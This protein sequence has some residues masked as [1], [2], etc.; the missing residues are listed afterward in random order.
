VRARVLIFTLSFAM[1]TRRVSYSPVCHNQ[2]RLMSQ[3]TDLVDRQGSPK[4]RKLDDSSI[5]PAFAEHDVPEEKETND[6]NSNQSASEEQEDFEADDVTDNNA[7]S[8]SE[9]NDEDEDDLIEKL[10][11]Q[12]EKNLSPHDSK[13]NIPP[14]IKLGP[15][16]LP[17][18]YFESTKCRNKLLTEQLED[19]IVVTANNGTIKRLEP[20]KSRL[21]IEKVIPL[22]PQDSMMLS[23]IFYRSNF[24]DCRFGVYLH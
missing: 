21:Q 20:S 23:F 6:E 5:L 19:S 17:K 8:N 1:H 14:H 24:T 3:E 4:R 10:L 7:T 13:D 2:Q 11:R 15:G 12:A 16:P 9:L 22:F 18:P